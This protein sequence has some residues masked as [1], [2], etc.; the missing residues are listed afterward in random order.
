[1]YNVGMARILTRYIH[2]YIYYSSIK[3]FNTL[4]NEAIGNEIKLLN[5]PAHAL[6]STL[7]TYVIYGFGIV[8]YTK[9]QSAI[10]ALFT[11]LTSTLM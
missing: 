9:M 1:M 5:Q 2:M 11:A 10:L 4:Y 3:I 6:S 8:T 7:I